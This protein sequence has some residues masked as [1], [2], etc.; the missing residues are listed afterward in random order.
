[1]QANRKMGEV[2]QQKYRRGEE[3]HVIYSHR[4]RVL[5]DP[6]KG[7]HGILASRR[8]KSLSPLLL[9]AYVYAPFPSMIHFILKVKTV[10]SSKTMVSYHITTWCHSPE[11]HNLNHHCENLRSHNI[12]T[13][14]ITNKTTPPH[15]MY[16]HSTAIS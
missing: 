11:D 6:E 10:Q 1:M 5:G 15:H 3:S 4:K 2:C 8:R 9:L 12:Q 14:I 13:R 7:V 16:T